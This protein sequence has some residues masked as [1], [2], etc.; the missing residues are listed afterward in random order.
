MRPL[1]IIF[2]ALLGLALSGCTDTPSAG[3]TG[4][5][6]PDFTIK[7]SDHTVS[8]HDYRGK[9]VVL[10]FWTTWCP[11]CIEEMPALMELQQRMGDKVVVLGVSTDESDA[12]YHQFLI[13]HK[14]NFLTVRDADAAS[15]HLYRTTGQPETF[16][17]DRQFNIRRKFIGAQQWASS[18]IVEY[19]N[20]L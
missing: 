10:N 8:L 1:R 16:I 5:E 11:P 7:D 13:K 17:I 15:A 14:I 9:V 2:L 19:L 18:E 6:A 3:L 4:K 12:A 20:K